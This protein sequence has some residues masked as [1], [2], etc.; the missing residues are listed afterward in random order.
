MKVVLVRPKPHRATINLQSFMICEPLELEI[1]ATAL[2]NEGHE[3]TIIDLLLEKKPLHKMVTEADFICF[4]S[5]LVHVGVVIDSARSIK[6]HM[7]NTKVIVG[8]IHAEVMGSDFVDESID[9]IVA[10]KP[11]ET[12]IKIL[13][14]DD[15]FGYIY[16]TKGKLAPISIDVNPPH[17]NR[18]LTKKYR[19]Q[20]NYVLHSNC[21]TIKTSFGCPYKCDFCFCR[22][23]TGGSWGCRKLDEW[24]LELQ[25]I[26]EPNVFIVDDNFLRSSDFVKAF[27]QQLDSHKINKNYILFGRADFISQNPESISLLAQYGL[28]AVFV[29]IESFTLEELES[30]SK[31][32]TVEMNINAI[33]TLEKY[34]VESYLGLICQYDWTRKDFDN[35]IAYLNQFKYPFINLQP[36]TPIPGTALYEQ[37]KNNIE[38][39]RKLFHLW[40]MAHLAKKP[41]NMSI[42][43]FYKNILRVYYKTSASR[44][45]RVYIRKKYGMKVFLRT[46]LGAICISHQYR[47]L[48]RK[49]R[50]NL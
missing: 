45:M 47:V 20:Y 19:K 23:I 30:V 5:Y 24:I 10:R 9:F 15:V 11:I 2:L 40:D 39:D 7:P 48:A 35:L 36:I 13:R 25:K 32:T 28:K 38:L 37:E 6:K 49:N 50:I 31:K 14:G 46:L 41:T 16:D 44:R 26:E 3:V 22:E 4:T 12:V 34:D 33:K 17:P 42:R 18:G 27:C 43:D 21:A 1:L 29:G 8:G